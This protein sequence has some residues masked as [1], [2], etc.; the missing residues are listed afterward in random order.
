MSDSTIEYTMADPEEG[1]SQVEVTYTD[2][3]GRSYKRS[4]NIPRFED[5][6]INEEYFDE[7][8]ASQLAGVY[9]KRKVGV[10]VFKSPEELLEEQES[11][12]E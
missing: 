11:L 5:G 3:D 9:N 6:T 4:V 7:I 1:Q 10:A 12:P 2:T 8:L